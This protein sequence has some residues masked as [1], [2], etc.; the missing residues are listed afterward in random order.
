MR[1]YQA[2][3]HNQ[4]ERFFQ[5]AILII[6]VFG[7]ILRASKYLPAWSMR[8]DEL[9]VTLNLINRSPIELAT[10]PLDYE[11]AAPFGFLLLTKA[12]MIIFGKSEYVLRLV[13]FIAGCVSLV[14]M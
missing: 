14:L 11:Q 9:A 7:I 10:K 13:S 1:I 8:G 12:L 2:L 6:I 3:P 5:I 4:K